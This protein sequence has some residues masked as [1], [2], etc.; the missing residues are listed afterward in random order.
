M[1][2]YIIEIDSNDVVDIGKSAKG[3]DRLKADAKVIVTMPDGTKRM[4][5][6][7]GSLYLTAIAPAKDVEPAAEAKR[8]TEAKVPK[9][10]KKAAPVTADGGTSTLPEA[11]KALKGKALV[12]AKLFLKLDPSM[13]PEEAA[14]MA[15]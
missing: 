4:A 6:N 12:K 1:A 3:E 15:E 7:F 10:A 8:Q 13:T 14:I 2:K 9:A 5:R 11:F